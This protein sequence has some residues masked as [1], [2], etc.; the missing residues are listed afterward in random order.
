MG[1][2]DYSAVIQVVVTVPARS[3][4]ITN[5]CSA[6]QFLNE[7]VRVKIATTSN[8]LNTRNDLLTDDPASCITASLIESIQRG[9]SRTFDVTVGNNYRVFIGLGL[10]EIDAFTCPSF[11]PYFKRNW[12]TDA[13]TGDFYYI[14]VEVVVS[15][16]TNGDLQMTIL[17][18]LA[19][20]NLRITG[21]SFSS[22]VPFN[23]TPG[24]PID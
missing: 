15:G 13:A 22:A 2:T 10:F 18:S 6:S 24:D 12:T 9:D 1:W 20:G 19:S 8:G 21:P 4:T 23:A 17:G 5:N 7:V 3:L 16:H 14:W 11:A